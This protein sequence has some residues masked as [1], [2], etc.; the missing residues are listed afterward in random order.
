MEL[1]GSNATTVHTTRMEHDQMI[2]YTVPYGTQNGLQ[3][4]KIA[5]ANVR[6]PIVMLP[7]NTMPVHSEYRQSKIMNHNIF[8][9]HVLKEHVTSASSRTTTNLPQK[10][11]FTSKVR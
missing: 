8:Q 3:I 5:S 10:T 4:P 1:P 2:P 6:K 11:T 7:I 9:P